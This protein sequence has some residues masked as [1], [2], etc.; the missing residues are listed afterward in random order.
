MLW[1]CDGHGIGILRIYGGTFLLYF[2]I[3]TF[4]CAFLLML[5]HRVQLSHVRTLSRVGQKC[6]HPAPKRAA[7]TSHDNQAS[8]NP[9]PS[10]RSL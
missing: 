9:L 7:V 8:N 2:Y 1:R 5:L 3:G 6:T 10:Q 4:G